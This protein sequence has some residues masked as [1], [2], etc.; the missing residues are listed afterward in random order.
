MEAESSSYLAPAVVVDC[1]TLHGN[2]EP[3]ECN[4]CIASSSSSTSPPPPPPPS[5]SETLVPC[6]CSSTSSSSSCSDN[7]WSEHPLFMA[8]MPTAFDCNPLL[9]ALA[10]LIEETEQAPYAP[11]RR[12]P[13]HRPCPPGSSSSS[14][15]LPAKKYA[16]PASTSGTA[17]PFPSLLPAHS[18]LVDCTKSS[19]PLAPSAAGYSLPLP[20]LPLPSGRARSRC[21]PYAR[22]PPSSK[23]EGED[24]TMLSGEDRDRHQLHADAVARRRAEEGEEGLQPSQQESATC[25]AT[26]PPGG[27]AIFGELQMCMSMWRLS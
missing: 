26:G 4:F 9:A 14:C 7:A 17:S 20:A 21:M 8:H 23:E 24:V 3:A 1:V 16:H 12:K 19:S 22:P 27:A 18:T 10:A 25:G 2:N 5:P 6:S 15:L 11:Q 13:S